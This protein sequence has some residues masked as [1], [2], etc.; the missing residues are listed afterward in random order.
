MRISVLIVSYRRPQLLQNCLRSLERQ[1]RLP[2]EVIVVGVD[3]DEATAAVVQKFAQTSIFSCVWGSSPA[4]S[5]VRQTNLGLDLCSADVVAFIDDDA[6]PFPD[7]L[8]RIEPY[9]EDESV[10]GV[11]GRDFLHLEDGRIMDGKTDKVGSIT[12]FGRLHGNHHLSYP[13]VTDVD[14]LKGVNMSFRSGLV[15]RLDSRMVGAWGRHWELDACLQ[16]QRVGKRLVFDPHIC[17]HHF[18]APR[19]SILAPDFVYMANHNVTLNLVKHFGPWRRWVFLAYTFLWGDYPE[20]GLVVFFKDYL[21]RL[22]HHREVEFVRLLK[23]SLGGKIDALRAL[24]NSTDQTDQGTAKHT[25][26]G[27]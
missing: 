22:V 23:A 26:D 4:P 17:V 6:E 11:G 5:I 27:I 1:T 25:V 8:E 2:D 9:Y 24:A 21:S 19:P 20:M 10:G 14:L 13:Q 3:G 15:G 12:W 16:I 18:H 7:W